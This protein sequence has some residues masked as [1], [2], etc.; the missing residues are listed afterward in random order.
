LY[1][2]IIFMIIKHN[3]PQNSN[4]SYKKAEHLEQNM[5]YMFLIG[6]EN[7]KQSLFINVLMKNKGV[8]LFTLLN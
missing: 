4:Y 2:D 8:Y 6:P 3:S 5:G 1:C 7:R